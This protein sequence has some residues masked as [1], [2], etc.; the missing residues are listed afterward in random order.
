MRSPNEWRRCI[1]K[2]FSGAKFIGTAT[3][4]SSDRAITTAEL[5]ANGDRVLTSTF[6]GSQNSH[7]LTIVEEILPEN[8]IAILMLPDLP[9]TEIPIIARR[10]AEVTRDAEFT[11]TGY[12]ASDSDR[13]V[14]LSGTIRPGPEDFPQL[15][16]DRESHH[17]QVD[18]W[19]LMAKRT[20]CMIG[21]V[22][23]NPRIGQD[24]DLR[25]IPL[26]LLVD[27]GHG[28]RSLLGWIPGELTPYPSIEDSV[29]EEWYSHWDPRSRG[30][31]SADAA[32]SRDFYVEREEIFGELRRKARSEHASVTILRGNPGSGKS[33][34]LARFVSDFF[35][36]EAPSKSITAALNL[37]GLDFDQA[38]SRLAWLLGYFVADLTTRSIQANDLSA[39][40]CVFDS[41]DEMPAI[42]RRRFCS[43]VLLP[44]KSA[45]ATIIVGTRHASVPDL[46]LLTYD[47]IDVD[48]DP[49]STKVVLYEYVRRRI[50]EMMKERPDGEWLAATERV[51]SISENNFLVAA[52]LLFA[53][54]IGTDI[55]FEETRHGLRFVVS[56]VLD[57]LDTRHGYPPD[58]TQNT[59]LPIALAR[60]IG[61]PFSLWSKYIEEYPASSP[62]RSLENFIRENRDLL[63]IRN[64]QG[65]EPHISLFHNA[66][67]EAI[68][69][70]DPL[71]A[72]HRRFARFA[73]GDVSADGTVT[74]LK[75]YYR[76]H[77]PWHLGEAD[78]LADYIA[79]IRSISRYDPEYLAEAVYE[80]IPPSREYRIAVD[81]FLSAGLQRDST[82]AERMFT[83]SL[84]DSRFRGTRNPLPQDLPSRLPWHVVWTSS[85]PRSPHR[86]IATWH[87]GTV[88][89]VSTVYHDSEMLMVTG[90]NDGIVKFFELKSGH[91]V[92]SSRNLGS[93][94][95]RVVSIS[96]RGEEAETACVTADGKVWRVALNY[97]V[98]DVHTELLTENVVL[99]AEQSIFTDRHSAVLAC[100]TRAGT[101][102]C[103]SW[104]AFDKLAE[105]LIPF[106]GECSAIS[107]SASRNDASLV[108]IGS[109]NGEIAI[110]DFATGRWISYREDAHSGR[111]RTL[112]QISSDQ[113][114]LLVSG[115]DDSVLR[116]WKVRPLAPFGEASS[117]VPARAM[118]VSSSEGREL[119]LSGIDGVILTY[120]KETSASPRAYLGHQG[121]IWS[122]HFV[123]DG[124]LA[125]TLL[126]AG[127]DAVVRLWDHRAEEGIHQQASITD[128]DPV[129]CVH[130]AR[131]TRSAK[132]TRSL[133]FSA[134]ESGLI[135]LV[136]PLSGN[137]VLEFKVDSGGPVRALLSLNS[138]GGGL[139]RLC[140]GCADGS[141]RC[142]EVSG[143]PDEAPQE[144][145]RS[146]AHSGWTRTLDLASSDG[147]AVI[148]STGDD[149]F[150]SL[151][152]PEG[153][154]LVAKID[155]GIGVPRVLQ[156]LTLHDAAYA[157]TGGQTGIIAIVDL[158]AREVIHRFSSPSEV[159]ISALDGRVRRQELEIVAGHA[160]GSL[161]VVR[162]DLATGSTVTRH[163]PDVHA[164]WVR[165]LAWD[166]KGEGNITSASD[167][168]TLRT[169]SREGAALHR[170]L[171]LGGPAYA[172]TAMET[173]VKGMVV[174]V[175]STLVLLAT[176]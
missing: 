90:A 15:E 159:I 146:P 99:C 154:Y 97:D 38:H 98:S 96:K 41:F 78:L 60:G 70:N 25:L 84:V 161:F 50:A 123:P 107:V 49:E 14:E 11:T 45:G 35:K 157:I 53:L 100:V 47:S 56:K 114:N 170:P 106:S 176:G 36:E 77:L 52:V 55:S 140:V 135:T 59:L 112:S 116:F 120:G 150:L 62:G 1:I 4:I 138:V 164:D 152:D 72:G 162:I 144:I 2:I 7:H 3:M 147:G 67:A 65:S 66:F 40:I 129:R 24:H 95:L 175:A 57:S 74:E 172:G 148:V 46:A 82:S 156:S 141:I 43:D 165:V 118:A 22:S 153:G 93:P 86:Q 126:S 42:A 48:D 54:E 119:V 168:G 130:I 91:M 92:A 102:C 51:L 101:L 71:Q 73:L 89:S 169:T 142:M 61:L 139:S 58:F 37:S 18:G 34:L 166:V 33:A 8:G 167:D 136:E 16:F 5:I 85:L 108:S 111:I 105:M 68:R 94:V 117:L 151:L 124:A 26:S 133:L 17:F 128:Y 76:N 63:V 21:M 122:L 104:P 171:S 6:L 131:E 83:L 12:P 155:L 137:R 10:S 160:D 44:M 30:Y 31:L 20:G 80:F 75:P 81:V 125:G 103:F 109:R 132:S 79:D 29:N 13:L 110:G 149:G 9:Q 158:T 88:W 87:Q 134:R 173:P 39:N 27:S 69:A 121:I 64:S 23:S 174:S 127:D 163:L 143:E 28:L 32:G 113:G 145:W 19:P 115:S